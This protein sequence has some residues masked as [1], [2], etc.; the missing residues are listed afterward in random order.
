MFLCGQLTFGEYTSFE[1]LAQK[2]ITP[3]LLII[4][5]RPQKTTSTFT[6]D[7]NYLLSLSFDLDFILISGDFNIH[8]DNPGDYYSREPSFLISSPLL[9]FGTVAFTPDVNHTRVHM[10][11]TRDHLF[12]WT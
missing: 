2:C 4:V 10:N 3:V 7:F 5:Y 6:D 11:H 1:Y 12:K 8:V 9:C